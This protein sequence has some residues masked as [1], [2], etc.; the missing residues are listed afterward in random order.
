LAALVT[1]LFYLPILG[2]GFAWDDHPMIAEN[3]R[4]HA[5]DASFWHWMLTNTEGS[6]WMPLTW[7]SLG[8]D[9]AL[10]GGNPAFFH[11]TNL[12][13]HSANTA[14]VFLLGVSILTRGVRP[15][16]SGTVMPPPPWT[17]PAALMGSILFGLHPIHVESVAWA[18][19]RKDVLYA[20]FYLLA[21]RAYIARAAGP[22]AEPGRRIPCL[23]FFVLSLASKPMAV[24]L[25]LVLLVLDA[26]PLGR[27]WEGW[28]RL[29]LEKVPFLVLSAGVA[30]LTLLGES[31]TRS[32]LM[33][34]GFPVMFRGLNAIRSLAFYTWK[35]LVPV[36]LVPL[37]PFPPVRDA[38]YF[39]EDA[40]AIL[41][42]VAVT[43]AC[44][45]ARS[46]APWAGAAWAFYVLTLS[47]TLGWV[48]AGSQAAAD[49]FTY[50]PS[51]GIFLP[52]SVAITSLLCRHRRSLTLT[53]AALAVLLGVATQRQGRLWKDPVT[54]WESVVRV[55]P[56]RSHF[57][58]SN[59]AVHYAAAGRLAEA[60][61]EYDRALALPPSWSPTHA[62]RGAVLSRMGRDEE[63]LREFERAVA[64]DPDDAQ[65]RGNLWLLH[66]RAGRFEAALREIGIAVRLE[67]L[68]AQHH[69][70]RGVSLTQGGRLEEAIACHRRAIALDPGTADHW[71]NLGNL[72]M[73][74][75]RAAEAVG[76][77]REGLRRSP[78]N[79]VI[80]RNLASALR[81][82]AKGD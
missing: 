47:P 50:L 22:G 25:P 23:L 16:W 4:L 54:L 65:V 24:T 55:Y 19:E 36:D 46:R 20:L 30:V 51:L 8:M 11:F 35:M 74:T 17:L 75:G 37:Y 12:A 43:L 27:S 78:G 67:P 64:L 18:A 61:R 21:L 31:R 57:A 7:L 38:G 53:C 63:A 39:A 49:R 33:T 32:F 82:A 40:L 60:L 68:D 42:V 15:P 56:D 62:G 1:T 76:V 34:E 13:L 73:R 29:V 52:F 48:Q 6:Y 69:A 71:F 59:L 66:T 45:K 9:Q 81:G 58:H 28:R 26:W 72:Y 10:G 2:N 5:M 41:W 44:W 77:Y 3:V 14:L 80:E 70:K 79:P